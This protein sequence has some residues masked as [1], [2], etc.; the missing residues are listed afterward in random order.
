VGS[1]LRRDY[2]GHGPRVRAHSRLPRNLHIW[3]DLIPTLVASGRRV[4]N[5]SISWVRFRRLD[6]PAGT[7]LCSKAKLGDREPI[8]EGLALGKDAP[9]R[10][11][12][13][14]RDGERATTYA[15]TSRRRRQS[16]IILNSPYSETPRP[17][18]RYDHALR[19]QSMQ[20]W[21]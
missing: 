10:L 16:V 14:L 4:V 6:K 18:A 13:P 11:T 2:G 21:Q 3:D 19:N 15:L 20:S 7:G 8:V 1:A 12:I 5:V 17:L 9:G